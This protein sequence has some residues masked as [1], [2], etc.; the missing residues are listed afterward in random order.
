M[1][2]CQDG[3]VGTV[4]GVDRLNVQGEGAFKPVS[5]HDPLCGEVKAVEALLEGGG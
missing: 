1:C 5:V 4:R 3:A 2:G